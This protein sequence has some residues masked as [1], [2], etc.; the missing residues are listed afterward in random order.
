MQRLL[1]IRNRLAARDPANLRQQLEYV[2]AAKA[3][4]DRAVGPAQIQAYREAIR[5]WDRIAELPNSESSLAPHYDDLIGFARAF[6]ASKDWSD[7]QLAYGVAKRM[8]GVNLAS[9]PSIAG[10]RE[11]ADQA[12]KG[13]EAAK[14]ALGPPSSTPAPAASPAATP[15]S[16]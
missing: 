2:A 12:G 5:T 15:A 7:A 3:Y 4:G 1:D 14:S 6:E 16:N 13:A 8:A 11:K 9:D 10:W